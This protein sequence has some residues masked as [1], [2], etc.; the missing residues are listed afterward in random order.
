MCL[1]P[2][3]QGCS[4]ERYAAEAEQVRAY[5]ASRGAV[6]IA[7]LENERD[8][9]SAALDFEKAARLHQRVQKMKSVAQQAASLVHPLA[10]LDAVIVQPAVAQIQSRSSEVART[11]K[12]SNRALRTEAAHVAVYLVR[13]GRILGPGLYSVEGMRHPNERAGSTSLFAHPILLEPTPLEASPVTPDTLSSTHSTGA[14]AARGQLE[15]RLQAV[16]DELET[17]T[18]SEK[19]ST[20]DLAEHLSLLARWYYRPGHRRMG[21]IFF[22]EE[23][24]SPDAEGERLFPLSRI[25]RGISRVFCGQKDPSEAEANPGPLQSAS[26]SPGL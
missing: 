5:L 16:L 2:C 7:R 6:T 13:G 18:H 14:K 21:E 11:E 23:R 20:A 24:H 26:D 12:L 15:Q 1:A 22:R 4:D 25:L 17:Q 19:F 10:E 8:A 3:F 9:A